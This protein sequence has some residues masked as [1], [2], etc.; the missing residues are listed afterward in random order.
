MLQPTTT[1]WFDLSA[2]MELIIAHKHTVYHG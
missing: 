1:T 2:Q